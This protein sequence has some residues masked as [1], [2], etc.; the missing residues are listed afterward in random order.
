[1]S[2][3]GKKVTNGLKWSVIERT[4]LQ[5][6]QII[7]GIILARLLVP[8]DFGL[9][10]MLAIFLVVA[11]SITDSG[12]SA[13]LVQKKNLSEHDTS[14][15]FYF[16]ILVGTIFTI[17]IILVAPYVSEFYEEPRLTLLLRV[18]SLNIIFTSLNNV[19]I[20]L[21]NKALDFKIQFLSKLASSTI[22]GF[23]AIVFALLGYGVWSLV[24][25]SILNTLL[26]TAFIWKF[27]AWRPTR[28][29]SLNSLRELFSFGFNLLLCG[30]LN[31]IC[32]ELYYAVIGKLFSV[33]QLGFFSRA[34]QTS[35]IPIGVINSFIYRITFPAFSMIQDDRMRLKL[36]LRK[37]VASISFVN[38]P[39]MIGL[40]MVAQPTITILLGNQWDETAPLLQLFCFAGI[41]L[42][43]NGLHGSVVLSTGNSKANLHYSLIT[44]ALR[45]LFLSFTWRW[46]LESIIWGEIAVSLISHFLFAYWSKKNIGYRIKDQLSDIIPYLAAATLMGGSTFLAGSLL[47]HPST[48]T[49]LAVQVLVGLSSYLIICTL[50]RPVAYTDAVS[51]L[52]QYLRPDRT[53]DL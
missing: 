15:I 17:V 33:H 21:L 28:S 20:W 13:A 3:L 23:T 16:N 25:H 32:N 35:D 8:E 49:L 14:T 2:E 42:P 11:T 50:F 10:A 9:M 4:S 38:F 29:F 47:H 27:S 36:A 53:P 7:L 31:A 12:L 6:L 18:L 40:A 5:F 48:Y 39:T 52:Y 24:A 26:N 22:S 19:Q 44:N 34:R 51:K 30:Q 46:G 41:L 1:M 45:I 43:V 37:S